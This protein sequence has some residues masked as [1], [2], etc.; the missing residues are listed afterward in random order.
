MR[1]EHERAP[2]ARWAPLVRFGRLVV[3]LLRELADETA[4]RRHLAAAGRAAS[5]AEW[6]RFSDARLARRY[7]RHCKCC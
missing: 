5:P 1:H 3:A 2:R 4:Y 7:E 6:R